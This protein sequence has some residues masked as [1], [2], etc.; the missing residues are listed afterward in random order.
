MSAA[1]ERLRLAL[2]ALARGE[3]GFL[4]VSRV[5]AE[6]EPAGWREEISYER[7]GLQRCLRERSPVDAGGARIGRWQAPADDAQAPALAQALVKAQFWSLRSDTELVPGAGLVNWTCAVGD[8]V[9]DLV[10]ATGS[11]VLLRLAGLDQL[12]RDVAH[13]LEASG[14]GVSLRLAVQLQGQGAE[15][16]LRI[17]LVN[18]GH[19]R[20]VLVGPQAWVPSV[21]GP[22][23]F[24]VE[25]APLPQEAP[26]ETGPG[27]IFQTWPADLARASRG[28]V[29]WGDSY[30]VLS[31]RQPLLLPQPVPLGPLP[32][33][34]HIVR[35]V[36]SNY[37]R[38]SQVAGLP[39]ILG[40]AFSNE[41][42]MRG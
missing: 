39:V 42:V 6:G 27:A 40:R 1:A 41:L 38:L 12:L 35:V 36:Y 24:R 3:P 11:P 7:G 18:E 28:A 32:P 13:A 31:P 5:Q 37:G 29:P 4:A 16:A 2:E 8:A 17:G 23:H 19:Q 26:D 33:G 10:V 9:V 30:I 22:N 20:A 34:E 21:D 14:T 15:Q 25:L